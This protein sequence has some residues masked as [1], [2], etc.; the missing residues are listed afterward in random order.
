MLAGGQIA[1]VSGPLLPC[2]F[3]LNVAMNLGWWPFFK[4]WVIKSLLALT[5]WLRLVCPL[6]A[7]LFIPVVPGL[8]PNSSMNWCV[9]VKY[10]RGHFHPR[11]HSS[12]EDRTGWVLLLLCYAGVHVHDAC[13]FF[14]LNMT[15]TCS[16]FTCA[17]LHESTFSLLCLG[18]CYRYHVRKASI[19]LYLSRV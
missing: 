6:L 12:W 1:G 7:C 19:L 11:S 3:D 10:T 15:S 13:R 17:W 5:S 16:Y 2:C 9:D 8:R 18:P 4:D 14:G